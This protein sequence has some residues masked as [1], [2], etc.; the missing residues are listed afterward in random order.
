VVTSPILIRATLPD[1]DGLAVDEA[2]NS[3]VFASSDVASCVTNVIAFYN[4]ANSFSALSG[5]ISANRS[6]VANICMLQT[7]ELTGFLHGEPHGSPIETD[8]FTLGPPLGTNQL[9]DQVAAVL[10]YHATVS[11]LPEHGPIVARP[12][13]EKAQDEGAPP[14]HLAKTRPRASLRGRLYLGPLASNAMGNTGDLDTAFVSDI[15]QAAHRL[16][17]A[18]PASTWSVWSRTYG[19]VSPIVGGWVG[20]EFGIIRRRKDKTPTVFPWV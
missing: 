2:V 3:F 4:A 12:T 18:A 17:V 10:S 1:V 7:Y 20:H 5:Y 6:R 16:V 13:D 19:T 9:P 15:Q 14:T 11:A 8:L